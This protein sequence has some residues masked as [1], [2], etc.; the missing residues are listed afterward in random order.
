MY[1]NGVKQQSK[2]K[3]RA[4][5]EYKGPDGGFRVKLRDNSEEDLSEEEADDA[6]DD[7]V[8]DAQS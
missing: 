6:S 5:M 2:S 8:V 3:F 7:V 1:I 4:F